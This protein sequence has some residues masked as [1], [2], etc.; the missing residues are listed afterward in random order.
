MCASTM[1]GSRSSSPASTSDSPAATTSASNMLGKYVV[2]LNNDTRVRPGW[3]SA[4]V[5][6]AEGDSEVGAVGAKL[7]FMD[8]P[9]MI[10]NAGTLMLDDGSGGDRRFRELDSGQYHHPEEVFRACGAAALSPRCT[11]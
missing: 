2:L 10:Q 5:A 1:T 3:L 9:G 11:P 6:A 7:V 8:P 4:L